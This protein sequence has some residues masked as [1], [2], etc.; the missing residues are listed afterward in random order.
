M[1]TPKNGASG[2]QK[3]V[4]QYS[5]LVNEVYDDRVSLELAMAR[6]A[7]EVNMESNVEPAFARVS[8]GASL[9]DSPARR[10]FEPAKVS[11]VVD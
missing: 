7:H 5:G 10:R 4:N 9:T 3:V 2:A 8:S 6:T 1:V 11:N